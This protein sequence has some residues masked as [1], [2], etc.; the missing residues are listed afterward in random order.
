MNYKRVLA[1]HFTNG[2]SGREIAEIAGNSKSTMMARRQ[3]VPSS[4]HLRQSIQWVWY[5]FFCA[6]GL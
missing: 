5:A 3:G 4:S 6:F 1:L 2:M